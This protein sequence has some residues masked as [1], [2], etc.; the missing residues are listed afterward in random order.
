MGASRSFCHC[1]SFGHRCHL[2]VQTVQRWP[3]LLSAV[4]L[5]PT[6]SYLLSHSC[7]TVNTPVAAQ[8]VH[9]VDQRSTLGAASF[10]G[11]VLYG[12][13]AAPAPF[14]GRDAGCC[15][16]L[17]RP[18]P[19][20]SRR[21][22]GQCLPRLL[23]LCSPSCFFPV[24]LGCSALGGFVLCCFLTLFLPLLIFLCV[25]FLGCSC[26]LFTAAGS[27]YDYNGFRIRRPWILAT[28]AQHLRWTRRSV[29]HSDR[30]LFP[31][32]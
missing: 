4:C 17:L 12:G 1:S 25:L 21:D 8:F 23:C 16:R 11:P 10:M 9:S 30:F 15:P 7:A 19:R 20:R 27:P 28:S 29:R 14:L 5:G 32:R 18:P 31:F 3:R 6:S 2:P 13:G 24:F 26:Q 22:C